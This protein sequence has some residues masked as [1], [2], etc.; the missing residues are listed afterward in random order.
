ML[1]DLLLC[2][3]RFALDQFAPPGQR[4][5]TSP[6]VQMLWR[7]GLVHE[8]EVLS[9]LTGPIEDLRGMD[10]RDREVRTAAAIADKAPLILGAVILHEDLIGMPDVLRLT[11]TGYRAL[12]VKAG[13]ALEGINGAYKPAYLA[14]VA[15]YAHIL[16]AT[17]IGCADF[18]GIIDAQG[19][20][21]TYDLNLPFGRDRRSGKQ[22]HLELL[23]DAR[24][25]LA[26][27]RVTKSALAAHCGMCHWRSKCRQELLHADDL[28]QLPGLGRAIRT[29]IA[30]IAETIADLARIDIGAVRDR[31]LPGLG[32]D[33]FVRFVNRAKLWS[34]PDGSPV[35]HR[36][37]SVDPSAHM[38]D[39]DV[40]A[41]PVRGIVYLHGFWH[42]R[43][44]QEDEFVHFFAPSVDA[45]GERIAFAQAIEHF[46][47]YRTARWFHYS[48]YERTAYSGLQRRHPDVCDKG[49]I[50]EIF[51]PTRCT[52]LY[53]IIAR[54]T[55]WPLSS[56]GIKSVA[57]SIGFVWS[58]ADPSGSNSIEWFDTFARTGDETLRRRII[59]YN[60]DDVLASKCVRNALA[61]LDQTG[62]IASFRRQSR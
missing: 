44:G 3:R 32:T 46:R 6:F 37:L 18:A 27:D 50:E 40:E 7:D 14:Q 47:R 20:E 28:T 10:R 23:S 21:V 15:H 41:D 19:T 39:F 53:K 35:A 8:A 9:N 55:D 30:P 59:Q 24:G 26:G 29:T 33:R 56:Y 1:R 45:E 48:A 42:E 60:A 5:P 54:D 52:D 16:D 2:E 34:D 49:E 4:D 51:D 36:R 22:R 25:V 61:E 57:K 38:I 11:D 13:S 12:D 58:D 31:K 17:D 62:R 43:A